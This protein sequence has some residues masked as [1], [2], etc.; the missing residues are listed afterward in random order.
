VDDNINLK[1]PITYEEQVNK[2][3]E[4]NLEINDSKKVISFLESVN[5]Y[6]FTG[7]LVQ[8]RETKGEGKY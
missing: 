3:R 2:L 7:Y 8:F 1:K 5:Y 4:H 6:R